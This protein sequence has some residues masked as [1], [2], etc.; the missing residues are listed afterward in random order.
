M[1]QIYA[2]ASA[3]KT[4]QS[5]GFNAALFS[6]FLGASGGPKWFTLFGLDKYLF[7]EFFKDR[8]SPLNIMG[9]SAGAFRAACFGQSDP[10]AA[11]TRLATD[12]AN[13]VYDSQKPTPGEITEKG[14]VLLDNVLGEHGVHEIINNPIRKAH[15][16]VAKSN[17]FVASENKLAQGVGLVSSFVRNRVNRQLLRSQYERYIFQPASSDMT[18]SDPDEFA[19]HITYLTPDNLKQALLASGSIPIVMA[20]IADIPDCPPGM[21]RDGGI[22]DYHFDIKIHNPGLVLYPHFSQTLRAGWFDKSLARPVR[23]C[24]YDNIVVICPTDAFVASLPLKKIPDRKDFTELDSQTRIKV[25]HQVLSQ[26][27]QLADGF[28][29]FINTQAIEK[30][31][32]ISALVA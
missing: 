5:E 24:N 31:Q 21:Y 9:S 25:W 22:V 29:E 30:I 18:I 1:I 8:N 12:Y 4:I 27:E 11:I 13:T 7:G 28:H 20:G 26:S 16:V 6:G 2:G 3:L 19:T 15:F 10:V 32:P 17:G 23:E 14:R